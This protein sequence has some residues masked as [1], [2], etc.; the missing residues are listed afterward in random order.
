MIRETSADKYN[1]EVRLIIRELFNICKL[2]MKHPGDLL[3]CQQ[4]GFIGL[5]EPCLGLGETGLNYMQQLNQIVFPGIGEVTKD[6]NCFV[7]SRKIFFNGTTTFEQS[8]EKEMHK[9]QLIWEN[10]YFL[11]TL[12]EISHLINGEHYDWG[13]DID[14]KTRNTRSNYIK[15]AIIAKFSKVPRFQKLMNETYNKELRNAIT[16]T[17][18]KLIQGGI[19]LTNLKADEQQKFKGITF[20]QWE[21][22][23][24]KSWFLLLYIFSGLRDVMHLFYVPLSKELSFKGIPILTPN[25]NGGWREDLVYYFERGDRWTFYSN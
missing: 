21:E 3:V 12:K 10:G 9:Y 8:V 15:D 24:S 1:E 25:K 13:L 14:S 11:R 22:I 2:T 16:H 20:E 6:N 19:V 17:Q 5:G 7:N 23:F 4:N 18:Y